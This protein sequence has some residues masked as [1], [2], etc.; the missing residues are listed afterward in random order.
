VTD[1]EVQARGWCWCGCRT[2][3]PLAKHTNKRRGDVCGQPTRYVLGHGPIRRGPENPS[4]KGGRYIA[5]SGYVCIKHP[6]HP[7][8][9]PRGYVL[10]HLIVAERALGHALS[11]RA[12]VHH[13]N[14]VRHD[15]FTPFN[16]VICEDDG[17]H[18][19]LHQRTHALRA[20]GNP[21]W[22][23]CGYCGQWDDPML[24][25][26]SRNR[27]RLRGFHRV[28]HAAYERRRTHH[29]ARLAPTR[30]GRLPLED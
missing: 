23:K 14:E 6:E 9:N 20:C 24:L 17:Y 19:L 2:P 30:H 21:H 3:T 11:A 1:G 10:E 15:N 12:R 16:L 22:L 29:L 8:A 25:A 7:R 27:K 26:K 4:W 5:V 13:V 28:C 18:A